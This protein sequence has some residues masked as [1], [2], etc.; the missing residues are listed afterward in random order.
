MMDNAVERQLRGL[1]AVILSLQA[2]APDEPL[3]AVDR[4]DGLD[5]PD[6]T[7]LE[8]VVRA[9]TEEVLRSF[10][11]RAKGEDDD[12]D[13]IARW[14]QPGTTDASLER[15]KNHRLRIRTVVDDL[16]EECLVQAHVPASLRAW[17]LQV[18]DASA[19]AILDR[20]HLRPT[21][22]GSTAVYRQV[23]YEVGQSLQQAL[24]YKTLYMMSGRLAEAKA[25]EMAIERAYKAVQEL[26][27][28]LERERGA[29]R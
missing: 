14:I 16:F 15:R 27:R 4:P 3:L 19:D 23:M 22:N 13:E 8:Q 25:M 20:F 6:R 5:A 26:V 21:A 28:G 18:A 17:K 7:W 10:E 2:P 1:L 11:L 12:P 29:I 9:L 24:G